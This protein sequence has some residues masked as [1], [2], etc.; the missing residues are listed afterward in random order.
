MGKIGEVH[1]ERES[2]IE[3]IVPNHLQG[4][5][6]SAL[7]KSHPYEEVAYDLQALKNTNPFV[8][9]GAIGELPKEVSTEIFLQRIKDTMK[10]GSVR[11]TKILKPTIK[12]IAICGGSGSFM[13]SE[14]KK[15]GADLF[16]TSDF[17]YHEFFDSENQIVIADIG[18]Y[19]S[20]QYTSALLGDFLT[21]KFSTFAIR[22][23]AINTNPVNY[24]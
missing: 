22:I 7:L 3:V 10:A 13:L 20:E 2:K 24:L 19:E 4:N 5:V 8:G 23:S 6:V 1:K 17:K 9:G 21:Q 14:A 16:L 11:Y 12:R 18:H 15:A